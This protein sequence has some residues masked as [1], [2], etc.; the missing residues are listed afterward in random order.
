MLDLA[1]EIR[2]ALSVEPTPN[3]AKPVTASAS[4]IAPATAAESQDN[5][6]ALA[7]LYNLIKSG[8]AEAE[9]YCVHNQA[10]LQPALGE[11][12]AVA[13]QQIRD[14]DFEIALITVQ[15]LQGA[16]SREALALE[17]EP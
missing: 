17:V 14:Y 1:R 13:L 9:D 10:A 4:G 2:N 6:E 11:A 16:S 5:A 8:S 12:Y 15:S 3:E 7:H